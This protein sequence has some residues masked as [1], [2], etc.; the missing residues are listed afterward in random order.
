MAVQFRRV[1]IGLG[2]KAQVIEQVTAQSAGPPQTHSGV[3][4]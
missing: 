4:S 3:R 2:H 1:E